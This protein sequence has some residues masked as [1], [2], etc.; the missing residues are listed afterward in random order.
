M[1]NR[2]IDRRLAACLIAAVGLLVAVGAG[3]GRGGDADQFGARSSAAVSATG[4]F[5]SA[6]GGGLDTRVQRH[7]DAGPGHRAAFDQVGLDGPASSSRNPGPGVAARAA[8]LERAGHPERL[9]QI[10]LRGPPGP[11]A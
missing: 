9:G 5:G 8:V 6:S 1:R 4:V 7:V 2:A 10:L 3:V 11:S